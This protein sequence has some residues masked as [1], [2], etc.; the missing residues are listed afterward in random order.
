MG[1]MGA[2]RPR[3]ER[4]ERKDPVERRK[5]RTRSASGNGPAIGKSRSQGLPPRR[6][7]AAA[8]SLQRGPNS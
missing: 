8:A 3:I 2:G 7:S 5:P 6:G 1:G 4:I